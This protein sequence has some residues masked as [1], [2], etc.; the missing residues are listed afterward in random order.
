MDEPTTYLDINYQLQ[1]LELKTLNQQQELT[2]IAGLHELNLAADYS[3]QITLLKQV[4]FGKL[5]RLN[6]T[7]HKLILHIFFALVLQLLML[8]LDCKYLLFLFW[9]RE[10]SL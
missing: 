4:K 2:I 9:I 6:K 8:L 10:F 1:L 7:L 3:S 5:A